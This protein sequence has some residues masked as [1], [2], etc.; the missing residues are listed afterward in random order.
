MV[1]VEVVEQGME[2]VV[3]PAEGLSNIPV[4]SSVCLT[5][6]SGGFRYFLYFFKNIYLL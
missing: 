2:R 1:L 3:T 4:C 5:G 6:I